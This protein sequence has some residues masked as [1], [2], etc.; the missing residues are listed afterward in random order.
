MN[1]RYG[2]SD[3]ATVVQTAL[4]GDAWVPKTVMAKVVEGSVTLEG[5]VAWNF[6]RDAAERTVHDLGA[7]GRVYN[8]IVVA[9]QNHQDAR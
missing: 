7:V 8:N 9:S 1:Q 6:E 2:D 5:Q 3:F 4:D